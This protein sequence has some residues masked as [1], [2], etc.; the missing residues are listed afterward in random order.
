VDD[1][2]STTPLALVVALGLAGIIA[3]VVTT[4]AFSTSNTKASNTG[5]KS[6]ESHWLDEKYQGKNQP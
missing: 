3:L 4:L 5:E 6:V 1:S 2:R